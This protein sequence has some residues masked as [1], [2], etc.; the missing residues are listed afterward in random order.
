MNTEMVNQTA[1]VTIEFE[2][3]PGLPA[4]FSKVTPVWL[5]IAPCDQGS[6]EPAKNGTFQYT[7]SPWTAPA[8][9]TGR[10]TCAIGH[11]HDGGTHIDMV[12]NNQSMC[13]AIAAYGQN[14]GYVDP[15]GMMNMPGMTM[16]SH[17]SSL[18]ECSTGQLNTGDNL[19]V[20]AYYNTTE[21][22]PMVNTDGSLAPIMGIGILYVAL[23]ETSTSTSISSGTAT[24]TGVASSTSK[25]AGAIMTVAGGP[26]L[27]AGAVGGMVAL[28]FT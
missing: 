23:N 5:D 9:V 26:A 17:I 6:E 24:A 4:S 16:G 14:S 15:T 8:T 2:Y 1:V 20:T 7:S 11:V 25:A 13:D 10:I 12:K 21:Y 19:T 18:S 22:A 28:G 27:F 3:I